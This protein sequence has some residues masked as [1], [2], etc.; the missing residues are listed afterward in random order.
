MFCI[1]NTTKSTEVHN[2]G[3]LFDDK[4]IVDLIAGEEHV[5]V[6]TEDGCVYSC[7]S[8]TYGATG[9]PSKT[10]RQIHG[11]GKVDI[12]ERVTQISVGRLFSYALVGPRKCYSFGVNNC[13]MV[14]ELF[15]VLNH[16]LVLKTTWQRAT[17]LLLLST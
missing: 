17:I 4:K 5:L 10:N 3:D 14:C 15:L 7:G 6:L 12:P 13:A 11:W 2:I 1:E 9:R 16:S 8:T